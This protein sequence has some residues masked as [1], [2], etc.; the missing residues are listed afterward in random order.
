MPDTR[1]A[2]QAVERRFKERRIASERPINIVLRSPRDMI[3]Y[4]GEIVALVNYSAV[5]F[6]PEVQIS[7][8]VRVPFFMVFK[9]SD[10]E[11][12]KAL[13]VTDRHGDVF[14]VP[15]PRY[16]DR[17]RHQTLR[18]LTV[19]TDLVNASISAKGLPLATSVVVRG[20]D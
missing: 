7:D 19:L 6:V 5:G 11:A 1:S 9:D 8:E 17:S 2:F 12:P 3:D 4:L 10:I 20:V 16:G 15:Q 14:V 18:V 13:S